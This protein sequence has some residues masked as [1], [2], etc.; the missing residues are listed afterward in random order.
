MNTLQI[1][2]IME[3]IKTEFIR[4]ALPWTEFDEN[5]RHLI[6]RMYLQTPELDWEEIKWLF[7]HYMETGDLNFSAAIK[8]ARQRKYT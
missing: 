1:E 4:M 5:V 2:K 3:N 8:M 6:M 7:M